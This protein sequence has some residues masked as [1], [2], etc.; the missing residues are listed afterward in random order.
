MR[1]ATLLLLLFGVGSWIAAQDVGSRLGS[2]SMPPPPPPRAET[3]DDFVEIVGSADVRVE[4]TEARLVVAIS[5]VAE[6]A[7]ACRLAQAERTTA[8]RG[9]LEEL[10]IASADLHLDFIALAPL[11]EWQLEEHGGRQAAFERRSG[12]RISENLHVRVTD[13][14]LLPAVRT[15]AL[16]SGATDLVAF[17]Y[18]S[19][20]LD[21]AQR[22]ALERALE[23]ARAKSELLLGGA[24]G[25]ARPPALNVREHVEVHTPAALYRSFTP[26]AA[27]PARTWFPPRSD[28][29]RFSAPR[30]LATYYHGFDRVVDRRDEVLPMRPSIRVAATVWLYYRPYGS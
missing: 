27:E 21:A 15:A 12:W 22:T 28:I 7:E 17:D 29:P 24:F 25:S 26:R 3:I 10:G 11:Y 20:E 4:P 30:P 5:S 9:A 16:E 19:P 18:A 2:E 8:V 13:F 6:D 23:Q 14:E 1:T